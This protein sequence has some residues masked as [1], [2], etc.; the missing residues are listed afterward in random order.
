MS[1]KAPVQVVQFPPGETE[2]LFVR[3]SDIGK[4]VVGLTPKTMANWRSQKVGPPFS[5]INGNAYYSWQELKKF[6]GRGRVETIDSLER[7]II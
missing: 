5:M 1:K 4:V 6:F 3:G 2:P 7:T